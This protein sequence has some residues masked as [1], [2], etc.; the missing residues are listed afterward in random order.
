M[1]SLPTEHQGSGAKDPA[2][3]SLSHPS[4]TSSEAP[5][6]HRQA[7]HWQR[8]SLGDKPSPAWEDFSGQS[9]G[10]LSQPA[11]SGLEASGL[12]ESALIHK[13]Q[14]SFPLR[15]DSQGWSLLY[16]ILNPHMRVFFLVL[17]SAPPGL[18]QVRISDWV[19]MTEP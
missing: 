6:S 7:P 13:P 17:Q 3:W 16:S 18:L 19:S 15:P 12:S 11:S 1:F 10:R 8:D 14:F 9:V 5:S 4:H 2:N